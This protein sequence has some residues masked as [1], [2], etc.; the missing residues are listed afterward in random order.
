VILADHLGTRPDGTVSRLS[1]DEVSRYLRDRYH[2]DSSAEESRRREARKRLDYYHD[3]GRPHLERIIDQVFK[4]PE[5][6]QLRHELAGMALYQNLTRRIVREIST[7]YSE[8]AERWLATGTE[9]YRDFVRVADLD[10]QL[11]HANRM[12]NLCNDVLVWPDIVGGRPKLRVITPD[13]FTAVA[14]PLDPTWPVAFVVDTFP[15]GTGVTAASPH[16]LVMSESEFFQLDQDWRIVSGSYRAHGLGTMPALLLQRERPDRGILDGSSGRDLVS[17]HEAIFLVNVGLLKTIK[18]AVARQPVISGDYAR[19]A[20]GQ[21]MD[22]EHILELPEGVAAS[23]LDLSSDPRAYID[24]ARSIVKQTAANYG[25]P[26]S[27]FDLSYQATSGFEIELKRVGLREVRKQQILD[28]R[29]LE[30]DLA[31]LWSRVLTAAGSPYA[32]DSAG[33]GIDFGD[34]ET[35]QEPIARLA[36]YEKLEEL[37]LGNRVEFYLNSNP[38]ASEAEAIAAV[39]RNLEM[40]IDRMLQLQ[41]ANGGLFGPAGSGNPPATR[42]GGR[43]TDDE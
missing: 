19:V 14:H 26:E 36:Y 2:P 25:I 28:F 34:V 9:P 38:L 3:R 7:V 27:V 10:R 21:V 31:H 29:P 24:A 23:T 15:T 8:P 11:R 39:E 30:L 32:F 1:T 5:V 37:G 40:R 17:A 43:V 18:S 6:R 22:E 35:P 42:D 33:F 41:R 20:R 13:A 12:T 16:Y 4:A